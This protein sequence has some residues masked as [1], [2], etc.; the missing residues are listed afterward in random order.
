[1]KWYDFYTMQPF[2][3]NAIFR[4][5]LLRKQRFDHVSFQEAP[6]GPST[7]ITQKP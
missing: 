6:Y 4:V 5:F 2:F 1:L 7:I 3:E